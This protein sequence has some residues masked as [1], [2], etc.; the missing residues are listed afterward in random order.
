MRCS[1]CGKDSIGEVC[2]SCIRMEQVF[3]NKEWV[4]K[5]GLI[6]KKTESFKL[7]ISNARINGT[8]VISTSSSGLNAKIDNFNHYIDGALEVGA[9][10]Y[11]GK[12]APSIH[13][14]TASGME[15]Y[16]LFPQIPDEG[17]LKAALDKAKA[18]IMSGSS[19]SS[20]A[21]A[22]SATASAASPEQQ[23]KLNKLNLLLANGILS[24]EEYQAEK[25]K[26]GL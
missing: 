25:V 11:N 10:S 4:Y 1:I 14:K 12:P 19:E 23:E 8:A 15:R 17:S 13:I 2:N 5:E 18:N 3:L 9:S 16:L 26:L 22:A 6:V 24:Q 7:S 21:P 20:S